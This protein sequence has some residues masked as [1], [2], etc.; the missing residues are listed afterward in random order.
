MFY[1]AGVAFGFRV[2]FT[3]FALARFVFAFFFFAGFSTSFPMLKR[4]FKSSISRFRVNPSSPRTPG[5]HFVFLLL[6]NPDFFLDTISAQQSVGVDPAGLPDSVASVDGLVLHGRIPPRII[7]NYVARGGQVQSAAAR[8]E[9]KEK[10]LRI[11]GRNRRS[12]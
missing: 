4:N 3:P 8:F 2:S 10:C 6:K 5:H 1:N 12:L 7:K 9:R 11:L